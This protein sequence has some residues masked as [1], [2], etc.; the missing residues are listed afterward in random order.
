MSRQ[1]RGYSEAVML[2][3]VEKS[4]G[5][6]SAVAKNL[7]CDWSTARKYIDR[8][9]EVQEKFQASREIV[10]DAAE[11]N[12][13]GLIRAGEPE[14]S[15]WWLNRIGKKRGFVTKTEFSGEFDGT[16]SMELIMREPGEDD[17]EFDEDQD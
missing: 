9:P 8:Y 6:V 1:Q 16:V 11:S 2:E 7:E 10:T 13:I 17:S 3:A 12:I 14:A 5:L 15:K 4:N